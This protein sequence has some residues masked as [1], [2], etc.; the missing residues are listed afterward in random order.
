MVKP[1]RWMMTDLDL[2]FKWLQDNNAGGDIEECRRRNEGMQDF[3]AWL[4]ETRVRK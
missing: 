3:R 4:T 2:M 1:L